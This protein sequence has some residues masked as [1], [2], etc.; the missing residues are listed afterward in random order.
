MQ[1]G[2]SRGFTNASSPG[3]LADDLTRLV[4]GRLLWASS[5]GKGWTLASRAR[6]TLPKGCGMAGHNDGHDDQRGHNELKLLM[7]RAFGAAVVAAAASAGRL[8]GHDVAS[9]LLGLVLG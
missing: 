4:S 2:G 8:I 7:K 1:G 6:A 3:Q 9:H 5:R